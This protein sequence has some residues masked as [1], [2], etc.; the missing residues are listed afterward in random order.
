MRNHSS[1][2]LGGFHARRLLEDV[3]AASA[4]EYALLLGIIGGSIALAAIALGTSIG[5]SIDRSAIMV[6][7]G[8]PA[9]AGHGYGH[10]DPTG[11]A[12]GHRTSAC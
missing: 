3:R 2:D 4:A 11:K 8:D 5:C 12:L 7:G 6:E 10:S 9:T 1:K